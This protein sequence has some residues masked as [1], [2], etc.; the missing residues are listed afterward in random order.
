M[1]SKLLSIREG[2]RGG[3]G[4]HGPPN[5]LPCLASNVHLWGKK[6]RLGKNS[7][8]FLGKSHTCPKNQGFSEEKSLAPQIFFWPSQSQNPTSL[9]IKSKIGKIFFSNIGNF[10]KQQMVKLM[11]FSN[12]AAL[13]FILKN[14]NFLQIFT[15]TFFIYIQKV[16]S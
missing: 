6:P 15:S 4:G 11:F 10:W 3:Q 8:I 1:F 16:L 5:I 12:G 9:P 7:R 2:G 14:K 13:S